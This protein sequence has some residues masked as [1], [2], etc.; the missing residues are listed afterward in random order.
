VV[1]QEVHQAKGGANYTLRR[2][3]QAP[4]VSRV[5]NF[6]VFQFGRVLVALANT[7]LVLLS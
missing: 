5:D 6:P 1:N 2:Q 7:I 3:H 4:E